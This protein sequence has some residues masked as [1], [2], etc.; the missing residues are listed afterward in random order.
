MQ[1]SFI[2]IAMRKPEKKTTPKT[3]NIFFY[4]LAKDFLEKISIEIPL[5]I[6]KYINHNEKPVDLSVFFSLNFSHCGY[7]K[8]EEIERIPFLFSS[9]SVENAQ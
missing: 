5:N 8:T 3:Q 4:Q 1:V 7:F 6:P 9:Q 2:G